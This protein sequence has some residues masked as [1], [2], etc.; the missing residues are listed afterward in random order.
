MIFERKFMLPWLI[1]IYYC[2][3]PLLVADDS[4]FMYYIIV[5]RVAG[6]WFIIVI[7]RKLTD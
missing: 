2:K 5:K 4:V 3:L 1:L 6:L 7:L